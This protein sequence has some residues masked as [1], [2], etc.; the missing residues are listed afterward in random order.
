[1]P[2]TVTEG[3]DEIKQHTLDKRG[4]HVNNK[5]PNYEAFFQDGGSEGSGKGK[6]F[7]WRLIKKD[8]RPVIGASILYLF[9]NLPVWI[10]PLIISD[11][12]DLLTNP[13]DNFLFRIILD[14]IISI[15]LIIQNIP[16]TVWRNGLLNRTIRTRSA[17]VK[18][19]VVRKLQ[20]LSINI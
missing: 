7:I 19:A 1:M 18:R 6:G 12:I 9:Q 16:V 11:V 10:M 15:V 14:A 17:E 5:I 8:R 13:P 20:K 3:M 4:R 2:K